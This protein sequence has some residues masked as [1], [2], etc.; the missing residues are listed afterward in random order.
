[1]DLND[2]QEVLETPRNILEERIINGFSEFMTLEQH[3]NFKELIHNMSDDEFFSLVKKGLSEA[4]NNPLTAK[5]F[6]KFKKDMLI[7]NNISSFNSAL[8]SVPVEFM[9]EVENV[10]LWGDVAKSNPTDIIYL[11]KT[12]DETLCNFWVSNKKGTDI[13]KGSIP[14]DL[15]FANTIPLLDFEVVV[16]ET[17]DGGAICRFRIVIFE[18]YKKRIEINED[19]ACVG[20]AITGYDNNSGIALG[21]PIY[22]CKGVDFISTGLLA[23]KNFSKDMVERARQNLTKL[24]FVNIGG[25][26]LRTWYG[27]QIALLHPTVKTIFSK[28]TKEPV[29]TGRKPRGRGRRPVKYMKRHVIKTEDINTALYGPPDRKFERHSLVWYVIGHWR[30][31]QNGKKIFIQPY[32]KGALREIKMAEESRD[33]EIVMDQ[34]MEAQA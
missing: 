12:D 27:V 34:S 17:I 21:W 8:N 9:D 28:P 1:M 22:V 26:F 2:I 15:F 3:T 6:N 10:K 5:E 30:T 4:Y 11:K 33:R 31:Y 16:D 24:N 7:R 32:W 13:E 19:D 29:Y 25:K 14:S 23:Y 18:D 20:V